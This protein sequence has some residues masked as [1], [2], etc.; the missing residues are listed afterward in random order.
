[1]RKIFTRSAPIAR[2]S[3]PTVCDNRSPS[4]T[5]F[6]S[7]TLLGP[8]IS[9][10]VLVVREGREQV[11][12]VS[13]RLRQVESSRKVRAYPRRVPEGLR[14]QVGRGG[15]RAESAFQTNSMRGGGVPLSE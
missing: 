1:M 11:Y 10:L 7:L 4:N 14:L 15:P 2:R 13:L 6:P 3:P 5:S 9:R 8:V 12:K